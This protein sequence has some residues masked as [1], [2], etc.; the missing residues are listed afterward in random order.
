MKFTI[1]ALFLFSAIFVDMA[2]AYYKK[3]FCGN[4]DF[5]PRGG[6]SI[7]PH[8]HCGTNFLDLSYKKQ[9]KIEHAKFAPGNKINCNK[10][11][12]VLNNP[13]YYGSFY[14]NQELRETI[15][16]FATYNCIE[17]MDKDFDE[18]IIK[19][20]IEEYE[21][22]KKKSNKKKKMTKKKKNTIK[23][24]KKQEKKQRK[25][26]KKHSNKEKKKKKQEKKQRKRNKQNKNKANQANKKKRH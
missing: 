24:K 18:A 13:I 26:N 2:K 8:L 4:K 22:S 23:Q 15:M 16:N 10:V 19:D 20:L 17:E 12:E 9:K 5:V 6:Q 11:I 14:R 1:V 7:Y 21:L 3:E 25:H